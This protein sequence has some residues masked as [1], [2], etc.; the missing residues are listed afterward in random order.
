MDMLIS[1]E[2]GGVTLERSATEVTPVPLQEGNFG[3]LVKPFENQKD[4]IYSERDNIPVV[5]ENEKSSEY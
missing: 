5:V 3:S 4:Q 2:L 1:N